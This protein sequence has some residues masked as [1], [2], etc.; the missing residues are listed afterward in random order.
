MDNV[1]KLCSDNFGQGIIISGPGDFIVREGAPSPSDL[2]LFAPYGN[3]FYDFE[4][5]SAGDRWPKA[6]IMEAYGGALYFGNDIT[7]EDFFAL[8]R[9]M[10]ITQDYVNQDQYAIFL[11]ESEDP[12]EDGFLAQI[13][14]MGCFA[15]RCL[16]EAIDEKA[17]E[18]F[19]RQPVS[20]AEVLWQFMEAERKRWNTTIF[21]GPQPLK[22]MFGGD[23]HYACEELRFGI[24]VENDYFHV[25][26]MISNAW[27]LTK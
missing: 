23:G 16:Y 18:N 15:L 5:L 2:S 11:S 6:P 12:K 25:C 3:E 8:T 24:I 9:I 20:R 14:I 27:L 19:P 17:Y 13:R 10:G 7:K 1:S 22:G 21:S 26:R 4:D